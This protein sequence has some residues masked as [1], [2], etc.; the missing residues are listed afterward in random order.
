MK[1]PHWIGEQTG[2]DAIDEAKLE[3]FFTHL[4][5]KVGADEYSPNYA[6]TLLMT[7]KHPWP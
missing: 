2:N 3:G 7:A 1:W 4:S 5:G 6:H